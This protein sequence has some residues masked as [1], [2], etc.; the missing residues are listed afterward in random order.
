MRLATIRNRSKEG[1][2]LLELL[3][4]IGVI[5]GLATV[6]FVGMWGTINTF[7]LD[8]ATTK[9]LSDIRYAQQLARTHN[10][11]YGIRFQ[12][13][14]ANQYSVYSTDG[15]IDT[16]VN[17][18]ANPSVDLVINIYDDY[19]AA[20]SAVDIASGSQL[21]FNPMGT[22]YDDK[23]GS[24]LVSNGAVTISREESSKTISIIRDTGRAEVE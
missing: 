13:D 6:A 5:A 24:P 10:G 2:T 8:A 23:N 1:F 22:P 20:V 18:P 17:N 19:G 9:V 11:W 15:M 7:R 12:V 16:N 3:V 14:P 21:E 4:M